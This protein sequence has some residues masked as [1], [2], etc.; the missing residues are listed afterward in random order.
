[1][2]P[3]NKSRNFVWLVSNIHLNNRNGSKEGE[4]GNVLCCVETLRGRVRSRLLELPVSLNA[5]TPKQVVSYSKDPDHNSKGVLRFFLK[6]PFWETPQKWV[7]P[8]TYN[9][10][11]SSSALVT[12]GRAE[13]KQKQVERVQCRSI[14]DWHPL[15][16][17]QGCCWRV[18]AS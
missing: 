17:I 6:N 12:E 11:L 1:M 10:V 2:Q 4:L 13:L 16:I 14:S 5:D 3:I 18:P 7:S 8:E 15:W 9:G